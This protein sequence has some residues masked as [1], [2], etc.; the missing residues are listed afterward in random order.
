[1]N[2]L[3]EEQEYLYKNYWLKI[4]NIL[5]DNFF[6]FIKDLLSLKNGVV[7]LS[8]KNYTYQIFKNILLS[9]HVIKKF[10]RESPM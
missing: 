4:E 5:E 9:K 8:T 6:Q 10:F 3:A 1:M 2:C 7:T